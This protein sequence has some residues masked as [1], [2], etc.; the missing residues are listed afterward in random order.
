MSILIAAETLQLR[1]SLARGSLAPLALGLRAE[2]APVLTGAIE[3]PRDKALLSR[4]G[5]RC[6]DDGTLLRFDP[7]DPR[8]VCPTC[9]IEVRG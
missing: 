2:L 4:T 5:G 8:H 1:R 3:I 6:P 9:G 7:V